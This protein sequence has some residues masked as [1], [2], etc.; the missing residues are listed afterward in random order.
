MDE[1]GHVFNRQVA[2]NNH[3]QRLLE[4]DPPVYAVDA[5]GQPS[6][7]DQDADMGT[8]DAGFSMGDFADS[9]EIRMKEKTEIDEMLEEMRKQREDP[10]SHCQV[11]TY[12]EDL[13]VSADEPTSEPSTEVHAE[14]VPL[15]KMKLPVKR[16]GPTERSHS[17]VVIEDVC[18][19]SYHLIMRT[20]IMFF[21]RIMMMMGLSHCQ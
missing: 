18:H 4:N 9:V 17:S 20:N 11:D 8:H 3:V 12:I 7:S 19:T 15:K 5:D 2:S 1:D 6:D 14:P 16:K 10:M 21:C 13:F